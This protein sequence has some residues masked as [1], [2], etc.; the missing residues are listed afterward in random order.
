MSAD[1]HK[2]QIPPLRCA[3]VGMTDYVNNV[4]DRTLDQEG[5]K[6]CGHE[7]R[8]PDQIEV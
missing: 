7:G 2:Q 8:C 1:T 3:P 5:D 4:G 6:T